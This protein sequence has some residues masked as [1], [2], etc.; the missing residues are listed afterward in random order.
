MLMTTG[1]K[2]VRFSVQELGVISRHTQG[3]RLIN[4]DDGETVIGVCK[5]IKFEGEEVG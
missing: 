5:V 3:V 4:V 2:I 1:G